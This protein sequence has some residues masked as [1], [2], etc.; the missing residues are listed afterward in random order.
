METLSTPEKVRQREQQLSETHRENHENEVKEDMAI[1]G[2]KSVS[3][4]PTFIVDGKQ[5]INPDPHDFYNI[6][7]AT[8]SKSQ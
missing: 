8:L 6:I 1:T 4:V 7:D 3:S 5:Y 2:S